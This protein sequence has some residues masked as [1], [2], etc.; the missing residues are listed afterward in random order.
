[1]NPIIYAIIPIILIAAIISIWKVKNGTATPKIIGVTIAVIL[2]GALL[3][4]AL[5]LLDDGSDATSVHYD[6]YFETDAV[7]ASGSLELVEIG[8][9]QYAH[10]E[11]LG[12]GVL[13]FSDGT[14]E[15]YAVSKAKLDVFLF[16]GQSNIA[17]WT[18]KYMDGT[19]YDHAIPEDVTPTITPGNAYYYGSDSSPYTPDLTNLSELGI[20]DMVDLDTGKNKVGS[21]DGSFASG[22]CQATGNKCLVINCGW[23]GKSITSFVQGGAVYNHAKQGYNDALSKIDANFN[24]EIKGYVFCQGEADILMD[25][26][27]YKADFMEMHTLLTTGSFS[28]THL[29]ICYIDLIRE[30]CGGNA[31]GVQLALPDEISTV[32][33]ASTI[34]DTFSIDGGTLMVDNLH[35]TQEGQNLIAAELVTYIAH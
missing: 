4:P 23:S 2:L 32:K 17:Y 35:Y 5:D 15:S 14:S 8:G 19:Y 26:D 13:S 3:V 16:M 18:G 9:T 1:M 28:D 34:A 22:Y 6:D 31:Y 24:T 25:S 30:Y 29:P 11:T 21:L 7:D 10:A 33:M 12:N 27:T 20:K